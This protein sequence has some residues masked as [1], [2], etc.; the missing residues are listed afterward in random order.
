M[1]RLQ[2]IMN[3]HAIAVPVKRPARLARYWDAML[4]LDASG[5]FAVRHI[6]DHTGIERAQVGHLTDY[7]AKL[8]RGSYL[9]EVDRKGPQKL[10]RV[11]KPQP[12]APQVQH[13]GGPYEFESALTISIPRS[14]AGAWAIIRELARKGSRTFTVDA[15][16]DRMQGALPKDEIADFVMR[17]SRGGFVAPVDEPLKG[18]WGTRRWRL[19]MGQPETPRLR[20][21][22]S[23]LAGPQRFANMWRTMKMITYF[24]ALDLAS[25]ASLPELPITVEQAARYAADLA[26]A[27]YLLARERAGE[28]M[29]YR[30][31]ETRNTG[32]AAPEVLRARFVWD[33]NLCRV[34]GETTAIEEV[35]P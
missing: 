20:P 17:L 4:A 25:A 10:Y 1:G 9:A 21:D 12:T 24:T 8:V 19:I 30:L 14:E 13:D 11:T 15:V 18:H 22:G 35:R 6:A 32:P 28:A 31:K 16:H 29:L 27:G 7:V 5:P 33:P 23:P 3:E 26:A 2:E 34:V